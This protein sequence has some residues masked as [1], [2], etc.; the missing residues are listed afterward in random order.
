MI[1]YQK[2]SDIKMKDF[3]QLMHLVVGNVLYVTFTKIRNDNKPQIN[4]AKFFY[5]INLEPLRKD[6]TR[7]RE[8]FHIILLQHLF[9]KDLFSLKGKNLTPPRIFGTPIYVY[10]K[11]LK[12]PRILR[13]SIFLRKRNLTVPRKLSTPV[14][15][16][17]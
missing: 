3:F 11:N 5:K 7:H 14:F 12:P 9:Q 15:T 10:G 17:N 6:D 13:T 16:K 4:F 8:A 1:Y 2:F